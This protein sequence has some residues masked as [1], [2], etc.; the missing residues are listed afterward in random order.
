MPEERT[1]DP[2]IDE[3][4]EELERLRDQ[5]AHNGH[6][7][8]KTDPA[9]EEQEKPKKPLKQRA[10][11]YVRRHPFGIA[12]GAVVLVALIIR[13]VFLLRYLHSYESTDDAFVEGH[14][15]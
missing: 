14:V 15:N 8:A 10:R 13:T 5:V 11:S 6:G 3:L 7:P 12:L 2:T 9:P 1:A 4:H